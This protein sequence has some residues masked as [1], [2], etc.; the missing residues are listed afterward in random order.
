MLLKNT[1]PELGGISTHLE[2]RVS[3]VREGQ[4]IMDRKLV[5][6]YNRVKHKI[7]KPFL[8]ERYTILMQLRHHSG[9]KVH[10]QGIFWV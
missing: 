10:A 9:I 4:S 8:E 5:L 7:K 3:V 1:V 2:R 6:R